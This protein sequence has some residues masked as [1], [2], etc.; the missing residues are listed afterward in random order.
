MSFQ[1]SFNNSSVILILFNINNYS[2]KRCGVN[3]KRLV[4]KQNGI[5]VKK[6]TSQHEKF[7][8]FTESKYKYFFLLKQVK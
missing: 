6:P 8:K 5:I 4:G 1:K 2:G 3:K 7:N